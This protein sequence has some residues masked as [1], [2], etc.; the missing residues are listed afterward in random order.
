[1][2]YDIVRGVDGVW[3]VWAHMLTK[4]VFG[5][6]QTQKLY[7]LGNDKMWTVISTHDTEW[8]AQN[9]VHNLNAGSSNGRAPDFESGNAGSTPAPATR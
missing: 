3:R 2:D 8:A 1:M 9:T 4:K 5:S 7:M 6:A